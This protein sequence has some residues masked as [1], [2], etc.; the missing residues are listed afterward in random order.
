MR[1]LP[2][3]KIAKGLTKAQREAVLLLTAEYKA[4]PTLND[5]VIDALPALRN[6]DLVE[7]S[8]ADAEKVRLSVSTYTLCAKVSACWYFRLLPNGLAVRAYLQENHHAKT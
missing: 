1:H 8:F 2:I 5:I 7:R 4:G 3:A 6:L